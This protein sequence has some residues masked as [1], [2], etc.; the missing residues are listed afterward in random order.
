MEDKNLYTLVTLYPTG[1]KNTTP[2]AVPL[3]ATGVKN[4]IKLNSVMTDCKIFSFHY[5]I[6]GNIHLHISG[7]CRKLLQKQPITDLFWKRGGGSWKEAGRMHE[8]L[9]DYDLVT[10]K[11]YKGK[12]VFPGT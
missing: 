7:E 12:T 3:I 8:H 5:F 9:C 1:I 2:R 11:R 4:H 6:V 10:W